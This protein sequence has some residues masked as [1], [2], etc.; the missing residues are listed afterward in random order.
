[1]SEKDPKNVF[2]FPSEFSTH[3]PF[4]GMT[5]R[6]YFAGQALA[7]STREIWSEHKHEHVAKR[8]YDLADAMLAQREKG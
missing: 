6:D 4:Y 3:E 7:E 8:A 1:M 2:A 5:L